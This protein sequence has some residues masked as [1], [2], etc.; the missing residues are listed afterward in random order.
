MVA[1]SSPGNMWLSWA[2]KRTKSK[3]CT[4][5]IGPSQFKH[6]GMFLY[7]FDTEP[8]AESLTPMVAQVLKKLILKPL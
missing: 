1:N 7:A 4:A 5:I 8:G 3:G 6:A 2:E